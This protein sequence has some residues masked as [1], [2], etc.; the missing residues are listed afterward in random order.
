MPSLET[1]DTCRRLITALHY[2]RPLITKEMEVLLEQSNN[3]VTK[4]IPNKG[5]VAQYDNSDSI[6][7]REA[8]QPFTAFREIASGPGDKISG[9]MPARAASGGR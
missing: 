5:V 7:F 8:F 6:E 3:F 2:Q 9:S 1:P 4:S